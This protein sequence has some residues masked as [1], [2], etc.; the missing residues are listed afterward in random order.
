MAI[1]KKK[2]RKKKIK[3][4]MKCPECGARGG[5]LARKDAYADF[6]IFEDGSIEYSDVSIFDNVDVVECHECGQEIDMKEIWKR[7][8]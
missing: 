8:A 6:L 1:I 7:E 5:L 2:L 4:E 3:Q